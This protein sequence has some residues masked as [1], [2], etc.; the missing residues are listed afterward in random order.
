MNRWIFSNTTVFKYKPSYIRQ[1][2]E[3]NYVEHESKS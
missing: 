1:N 3:Q 2:N